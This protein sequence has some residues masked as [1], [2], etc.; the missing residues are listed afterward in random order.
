MAIPH[1]RK[2][3][4]FM[5]PFSASHSS[6]FFLLSLGS[7]PLTLLLL[8][9]SL[10]GVCPS[11][12]PHAQNTKM[13][14]LGTYSLGILAPALASLHSSASQSLRF[15]RFVSTPLCIQEL[16]SYTILLV[17]LKHLFQILS[18]DWL[19]SD[20][21]P[22]KLL[23]DLN[24]HVNH[25]FDLTACCLLS[26]TTSLASP[27]LY[28][29]RFW[30]ETIPPIYLWSTIHHSNGPLEWFGEPNNVPLQTSI[31][32]QYWSCKGTV[33]IGHSSLLPISLPCY[34]C[35]N[36][37]LKHLPPPNQLEDTPIPQ[38]VVLCT[39]WKFHLLSAAGR[40]STD[41]T[42]N[43]NK[44][45]LSL[46]FFMGSPADVRWLFLELHDLKNTFIFTK[47]HGLNK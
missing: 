8:L 46:N 2:Q 37:L 4:L 1:F 13:V 34:T 39:L 32:L 28:S 42:M 20:I 17:P 25:L 43:Y 29:Q 21:S 10:L 9:S 26:L 40:Y 27:C 44:N 33:N 31:K 38:D 11:D 24:I 3:L 47:V 41:I 45:D 12:T 16:L 36:P 14:V 19:F 30:S 35:Q 23:S 22:T 5:I 6:Y 15:T 7:P 18:L